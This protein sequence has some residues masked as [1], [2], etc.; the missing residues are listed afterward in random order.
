M[1]RPRCCSPSPDPAAEQQPRQGPP[2]RRRRRCDRTCPPGPPLLRQRPLPGHQTRPQRPHH[3]PG[4]DPERHV[5]ESPCL[6]PTTPLIA[7]HPSAANGI[8]APKAGR[9]RLAQR[10]S[11]VAMPLV[12]SESWSRPSWANAE[13]M[14]TM[15]WAIAPPTSLSGSVA[16]PSRSRR[17]LMPWGL[18]SSSSRWRVL[19]PSRSSFHDVIT[20]TEMV[21]QPARPRRTSAPGPWRRT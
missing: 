7:Q 15:A 5:K 13:M 4:T 9:P 10:I 12:R 21:Q 11:G 1:Q 17:N 6:P 16:M 14:V 8:T 19:R 18:K 20:A 2:A 3:R